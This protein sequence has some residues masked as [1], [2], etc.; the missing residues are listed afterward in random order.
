MSHYNPRTIRRDLALLTEERLY[1]IDITIRAGGSRVSMVDV[2]DFAP[3]AEVLDIW[4]SLHHKTKQGVQLF[5]M[6]GMF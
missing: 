1:A 6:N 2:A 4:N 3:P 5:P